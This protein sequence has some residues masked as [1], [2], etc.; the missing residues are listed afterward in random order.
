MKCQIRFSGK[1]KT[2][3]HNALLKFL[4]GMLSAIIWNLA[5]TGGRVANLI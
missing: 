3:F 1:N 4:P 2:I 5:K